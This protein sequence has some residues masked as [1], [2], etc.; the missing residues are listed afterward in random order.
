M[1]R[2]EEQTKYTHVRVRIQGLRTRREANTHIQTDTWT[3]AHLDKP[4]RTHR[5]TVA[6]TT[7]EIVNSVKHTN[8]NKGTTSSVDSIR[9]RYPPPLFPLSSTVFLA[10]VLPSI[11]ILFQGRIDI[12]NVAIRLCPSSIILQIAFL[13]S[14]VYIFSCSLY[15]SILFLFFLMPLT[16]SV[17]I[18]SKA[19]LRFLFSS[20]ALPF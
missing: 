8:N 10:M 1:E 15:C 18:E 6:A 5:V 11:L 2:N 17:A 16:Y 3:Q 14:L 13:F 20:S 12:Y 4:T 19:A 9:P 7:V